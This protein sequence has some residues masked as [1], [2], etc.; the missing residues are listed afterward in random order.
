MVGR[1][2]E[3]GLARSSEEGVTDRMPKL[4]SGGWGVHGRHLVLSENS[5]CYHRATDVP[6]R[7][8]EKDILL[9][10][11]VKANHGLLSYK[12]FNE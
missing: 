3:R 4:S 11:K 8:L 5:V 1:A 12:I 10:F 9:I 6:H 7:Q 2:Y